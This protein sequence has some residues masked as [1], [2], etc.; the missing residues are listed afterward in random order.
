[1]RVVILL[2]GMLVFLTSPVNCQVLSWQGLGPVRLGMTIEEAERALGA[3][4]KPRSVGSTDECWI[5]Q[6]ADGKNEEVNY[7]VQN[8]KIVVISVLPDSASHGTSKITDTRGLG[9]GATEADIR[10]AYGE[11]KTS[12]APY[13]NEESEIEAAKERAR[14][15]V[16]LAAPLPSPEYWI[17]AES[18]NH[19]RAIIYNTRDS[20]VLWLRTGF[21]PAVTAAEECN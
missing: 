17:E 15:G 13:F 21:K 8:G 19:E 1:M 14:L 5:T 12:F 3:S 20:K 7:E 2:L 10:R 11:V 9:V 4:F 6:R 18:P 16:K